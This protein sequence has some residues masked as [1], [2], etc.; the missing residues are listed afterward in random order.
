MSQQLLTTSGYLAERT[1]IR[2]LKRYLANQCSYNAIQSSQDI[3]TTQMPFN[4][5]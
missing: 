4:D 3:E 1:E 2:L 5:G